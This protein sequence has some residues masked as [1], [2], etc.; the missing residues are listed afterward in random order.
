MIVIGHEGPGAPLIR[1]SAACRKKHG[2]GGW[3]VQLAFGKGFLESLAG[4]KIKD[5]KLGEIKA[6]NVTASSAEVSADVVV[7]RRGTPSPERMKRTTRSGLL[8]TAAG[9]SQTANHSVKALTPRT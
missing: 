9:A 2:L 5:L 3:G 4:V 1:T 8:K 7:K 6:R